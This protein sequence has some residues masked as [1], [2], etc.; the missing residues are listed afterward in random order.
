MTKRLKTESGI[1]P[2]FEI[3]RSLSVP[4]EDFIIFNDPG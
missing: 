2:E 3:V 1:H 4:P